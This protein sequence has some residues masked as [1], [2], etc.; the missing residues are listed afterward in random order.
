MPFGDGKQYVSGKSTFPVGPHL[1]II[2]FSTITIPGDERS[3]TNPGHGYPE[4]TEQVIKYIWYPVEKR[5]EWEAEIR[6]RMARSNQNWHALENG[7][8]K[9]YLAGVDD[10][11]VG[12]P[13]F[14]QVLR[15]LDAFENARRGRAFVILQCIVSGLVLAHGRA[16]CQRVHADIVRPEL[17]GEHAAEANHRGF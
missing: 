8:A 13:D 3:R 4:S 9:L 6:E 10:I 11:N 16:R 17:A 14:D 7:Q 5:E 15:L 2:E 1:A 12:S